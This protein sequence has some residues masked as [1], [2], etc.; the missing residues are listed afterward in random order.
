[1]CAHGLVR[2]EEGPTMIRCGFMPAYFPELTLPR[3]GSHHLS[4]WSGEQGDG[5]TMCSGGGTESCRYQ[6]QVSRIRGDY[7]CVSII[8]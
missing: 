1:M 8:S 5:C 6:R 2:T 4:I 7:K 3:K